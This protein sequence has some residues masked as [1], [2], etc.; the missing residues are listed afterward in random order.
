MYMNT[1]IGIK[2][3]VHYYMSTTCVYTDIQFT[4]THMNANKYYYDIFTHSRRV[5]NKV[6][7]CKLA[8]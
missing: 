4:C 8:F 2:S 1:Y 6:K 5:I 3:H 7:N